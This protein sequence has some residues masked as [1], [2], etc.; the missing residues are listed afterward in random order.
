M[1]PA[2][3]FAKSGKFCTDNIIRL[4]A[5]KNKLSWYITKTIAII[6]TISAAVSV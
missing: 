5:A 6:K 1:V 4:S 2:V 3:I